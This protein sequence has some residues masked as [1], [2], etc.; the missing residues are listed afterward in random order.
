MT[1]GNF[2]SYI[3][4]PILK[5]LIG[6]HLIFYSF[7][8]TADSAVSL[9]P[10]CLPYML[11]SVIPQ[12]PDQVNRDISGFI[13]IPSPG[14]IQLS[15]LSRRSF[16]HAYH[17]SSRDITLPA[18]ASHSGKAGGASGYLILNSLSMGQD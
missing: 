12:V 1:L 4:Y 8:N 17:D 16:P 15:L 9:D 10:K 6:F 13:K 14:E 3:L 5:S 7:N 18:I 11:Q 2:F